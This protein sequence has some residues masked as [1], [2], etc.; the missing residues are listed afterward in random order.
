MN[1]P[2]IT[3]FAVPDDVR[4]EQPRGAII[5]LVE[6][7]PGRKKPYTGIES[8][9]VPNHM[10]INGVAI[11]ASYDA[12]ATLCETVL[13]G[14]STSMF[15]VTVV[16]MARALRVGGTPSFDPAAEGLGPDDNS[17]AVVEVPDVDSWVQGD[18]LDRRWVLLNGHRVWTVGEL[19]I[20][21]AAT[22]GEDR[23]CALVEMTLLCRQLVVDDE[24]AD[25]V[26]H[27]E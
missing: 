16:V 22:Y 11:W 14:S 6:R 25:P 2:T 24:P 12:P 3:P 20:G 19:V 7:H 17:A 1:Q 27:V 21:R 8:I 23:Y 5:E 9:I 10:R 15:T 4:D 13:D 18:R 26:G